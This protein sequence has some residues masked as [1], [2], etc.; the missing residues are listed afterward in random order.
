MAVNSNQ[1]GQ[2]AYSLAVL[3]D[4]STTVPL[5]ESQ[6]F[7]SLL[8][9]PKTLKHSIS[10]DVI[11]NSQNKV[12]WEMENADVYSPCIVDMD[13]EKG[14]SEIPKTKDGPIANLKTEDPLTR[15]LQRQISIQMRGNLMQLLM[16]QFHS[17]VLP[18][19]NFRDKS[20]IE[21][22]HEMPNNRPRK[23]KRSASFNSR[24]V[25][26]LF[27]VLSSMGTMILIYLT[28]RVRQMAD[29]SLHG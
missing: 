20:V 16:D 12:N 29:G 13:I 25:V 17:V 8:K 26:L 10:L 6:S 19:F 14:K 15:A 22:V 7:L 4:E 3:P 24:K 5:S 1:E 2:D 21:R 11:L 23:Y 9:V 28:L 18:K 27:S